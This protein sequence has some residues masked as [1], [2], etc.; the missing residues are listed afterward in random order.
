MRRMGIKN[1][2]RRPKCHCSLR[3][4]TELDDERRLAAQDGCQRKPGGRVEFN[5]IVVKEGYAIKK[6]TMRNKKRYFQSQI[7][8]E[9]LQVFPAAFH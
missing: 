6:L 9:R 4:R 7:K 5:N 2:M 8:K 3:I 1:R